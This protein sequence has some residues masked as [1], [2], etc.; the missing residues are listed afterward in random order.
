MTSEVREKKY[1]IASDVT[2]NGAVEESSHVG[3][4]IKDPMEIV[5]NANKESHVL[6][7]YVRGNW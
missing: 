2:E 6:L 7:L 1:V 5:L 3:V 4:P